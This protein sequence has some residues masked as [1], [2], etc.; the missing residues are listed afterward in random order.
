MLS[1]G[2][3][4][5]VA[6]ASIISYDPILLLLNELYTNLSLKC[7]TKINELI[8]RY[9]EEGKTIV[10]VSH[11]TTYCREIVDRII[12]MDAGRIVDMK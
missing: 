11:D 9:R 1:Y 6:L 4:K 2:E 7:I 8:K 12:Y 3:K 10:I 5:L